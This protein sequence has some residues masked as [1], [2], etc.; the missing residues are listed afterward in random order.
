MLTAPVVC[1]VLRQSVF[2]G[3]GVCARRLVEGKVLWRGRTVREN[4]KT[5]N[6]RFTAAVRP[7]LECNPPTR[8]IA[9]AIS[10]AFGLSLKIEPNS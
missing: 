5:I 4:C 3:D 9:T 2:Q 7:G 6:Q 8:R 1:K 10:L